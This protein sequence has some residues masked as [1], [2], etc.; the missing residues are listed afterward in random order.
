MKEKKVTYIR[1]SSGRSVRSLVYIST[2]WQTFY[3]NGRNFGVTTFHFSA[4]IEKQSLRDKNSFSN[5]HSGTRRRRQRNRTSEK[6]PSQ[7]FVKSLLLAFLAKYENIKS[8]T[9]NCYPIRFSS[10]HKLFQHIAK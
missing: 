1:F 2:N 10:K 4:A 3:F 5:S 6:Y 7:V 9:L 8:F